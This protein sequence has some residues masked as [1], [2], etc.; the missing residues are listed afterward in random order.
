MFVFFKFCLYLCMQGFD[1]CN[2]LDM[3]NVVRKMITD[4]KSITLLLLLS[5]KFQQDIYQMEFELLLHS[6]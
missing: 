3:G 1:M 2:I 5:Q 4:W 6:L